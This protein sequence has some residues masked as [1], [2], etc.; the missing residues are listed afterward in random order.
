MMI[1]L[2][3]AILLIA[4]QVSWI[5][6]GESKKPVNSFCTSKDTVKYNGSCYRFFNDPKSYQESKRTCLTIGANLIEIYNENEFKF[7]NEVVVDRYKSD[8][9][10]W[11]SKS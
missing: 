9:R 2:T 4:A 5:W 3:I 10:L 7:L 11:V 8:L 6:N 1:K